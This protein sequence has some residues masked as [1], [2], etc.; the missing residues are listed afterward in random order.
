M[1]TVVAFSEPTNCPA[2]HTLEQDIGYLLEQ[3]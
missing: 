2:Q 3:V 1:E